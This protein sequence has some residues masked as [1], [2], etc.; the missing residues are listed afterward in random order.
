MVRGYMGS[1]T[2]D[3]D[4]VL[5]GMLE[6]PPERP[7]ADSRASLVLMLCSCLGTVMIDECWPIDVFHTLAAAC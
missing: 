4:L 3:A 1:N 2:A 6:L 7:G 5:A